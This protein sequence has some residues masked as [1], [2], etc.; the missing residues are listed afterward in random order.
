[1]AAP[2]SDQKP[3]NGLS[4]VLAWIETALIAAAAAAMAAMMCIVVA[5]VL[6]RYVFDS[7][8]VWSYDL[9]GLYLVGAVFFLALPDTMQHH[10]HIALDVFQPMIPFRIKHVALALGFAASALLLGAITWLE[11][12]EAIDTFQADDRI[13]GIVPFPTWVSHA[14]LTA[15]MSILTLRCAFRA[16]FHLMSGFVGTTMVELPPPP[17]TDLSANSM[18]NHTAKGGVE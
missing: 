14:V 9:I 18:D 12:L 15:G 8:L 3:V 7:P 16:L 11:L 5:D 6:M 17:V 2:I 10:G 13:A 4:A 1:M